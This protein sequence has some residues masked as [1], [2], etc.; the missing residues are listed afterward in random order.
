MAAALC[1]ETA[2]NIEKNLWKLP[3]K[4]SLSTYKK[5]GA[6]SFPV[7]NSPRHVLFKFNKKTVD[8]NYF[9]SVFEPD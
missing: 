4:V 9:L 8:G 7:T 3:F 1:L 5:G 6:S 2:A